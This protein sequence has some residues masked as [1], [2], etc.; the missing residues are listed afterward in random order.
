M[1]EVDGWEAMVADP[2]LC[3][4]AYELGFSLCPKTGKVLSPVGA[5]HVYEITG[6]K[7]QIYVMAAFNAIG[8]YYLPPYILVNVSGILAKKVFWMPHMLRQKEDG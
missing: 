2:R 5:R 7:T 6:D 8:N 4:N 3:F 1:P